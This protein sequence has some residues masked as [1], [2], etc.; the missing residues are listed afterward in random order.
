MA[1]LHETAYPRLKPDPTAKELEEIYTPTA[2]EIAFAKQLTTQPGPQLAVLI[3]LKLF[4]R[5]GYF[6]LLAEVPERIRQHIAKAARLGRVLASDQLER[7]DV[8]GSKRRHMPQLR[9]FIGV[10]PL[11]KSGLAWLDTVATAAAQTKHTIPDIVNVLL[12]EL[13]HHRYELPGFRTLELAAIGARE[14]VN[15]GY[16]RSISHA[17]TPATRTLID[18]LLRA[19]E[20]SRFTGWHS[21]KRE[22]G[23]PTNKEVDRPA[24]CRHP[25][26]II[27]GYSRGV[28]EQQAIHG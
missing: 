24:F 26:A 13:V 18:E 20:G 2:A 12:E 25:Q 28:H 10:R 27:H 5:L 9:Q 22:P 3:H 21:L 1:T 17:L 7:Y 8:S 16:Y 19:P 11:D 15:L 6:T 4:Q 23:R 14:R